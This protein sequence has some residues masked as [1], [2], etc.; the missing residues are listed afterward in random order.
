MKRTD[1]LKCNCFNVGDNMTVMNEIMAYVSRDQSCPMTTTTMSTTTAMNNT[2]TS[3]MNDTTTS[4]S[5]T[6]T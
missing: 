3:A 2:T 4:N 6:T 5:T 1:S